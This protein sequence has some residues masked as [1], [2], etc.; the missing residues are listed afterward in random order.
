MVLAN[1]ATSEWQLDYCI[2]GRL[3]MIADTNDKNVIIKLQLTFTAFKSTYY[4][5]LTHRFN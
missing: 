2:A 1:S 4:G 5:L 3:K